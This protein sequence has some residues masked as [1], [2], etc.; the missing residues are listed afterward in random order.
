MSECVW[1]YC[2]YIGEIP[3]MVELPN[4]H[5]SFLLATHQ[6]IVRNDPPPPPPRKLFLYQISFTSITTASWMRCHSKSGPFLH[7]FLVCPRASPSVIARLLSV[8]CAHSV[9]A[10]TRYLFLCRAGA[11]DCVWRYL[12]AGLLSWLALFAM[13]TRHSYG[14]G[15]LVHG[16]WTNLSRKEWKWTL[17]T[18][19]ML[20]LCLLLYIYLCITLQSK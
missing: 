14:E 10:N 9:R 17:G 1:K 13:V 2:T 6:P 18:F 20:L 11:P 8:Q 4:T 12:A 19:H 3:H 5:P 7:S 16:R 15:R